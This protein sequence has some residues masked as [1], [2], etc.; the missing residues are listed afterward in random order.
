[1]TLPGTASIWRTA[2]ISRKSCLLPQAA[3]RTRQAAAVVAAVPGAMV[4]GVAKVL[5]GAAA[6]AK[7]SSRL[8]L[9][10]LLLPLLLVP[11]PPIS[12]AGVPLPGA[13][14]VPPTPLTLGRPGATTALPTATLS[15]PPTVA[16]P[17]Q[18]RQQIA[19]VCWAAFCP[20]AA[21]A[22]VLSGVGPVTA[23][24]P[25]ADGTD[26]RPFCD[27]LFTGLGCY[28]VSPPFYPTPLWSNVGTL[29]ARGPRS[30]GGFYLGSGCHH[31]FVPVV[32][33]S[34]RGWSFTA[35]CPPLGGVIKRPVRHFPPTRGSYSGLTC[36][37]TISWATTIASATRGSDFGERT[38]QRRRRSG[39]PAGG[40]RSG[41][42]RRG[43]TE[44][45]RQGRGGVSQW[46]RR[47]R[48]RRRDQRRRQRPQQRR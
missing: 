28:A 10:P 23:I 7:A 8:A 36:R 20:A 35:L 1:M 33:F 26:G 4:G 47:R 29:R 42:E 11:A 19:E 18:C 6:V 41:T 24:G 22:V 46:R 21:T 40:W 16:L 44:A 39:G 2:K 25:P 13:T 15:T 12:L 34:S 3:L 14:T 43:R 27:A 45:E 9:L 48:R 17:R 32:P 5:A 30:V 38:T 31:R 37:P